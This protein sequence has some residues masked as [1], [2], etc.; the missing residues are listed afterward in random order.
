MSV[1]SIV[2]MIL[3]Y[4]QGEQSS[5]NSSLGGVLSLLLVCARLHL[6]TMTTLFDLTK[7][8]SSTRH[9]CPWTQVFFDIKDP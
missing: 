1:L 7:H 3:S 6:Y 8:M 2:L 4:I 9:E 5:Q